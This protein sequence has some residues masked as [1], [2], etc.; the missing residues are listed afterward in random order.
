M[1]NNPINDIKNKI[2]A[3]PALSKPRFWR[4]KYIDIDMKTEINI[5]THMKISKNIKLIIAL[6]KSAMLLTWYH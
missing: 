4:E 1:W 3:V 5:F 6:K 2:N